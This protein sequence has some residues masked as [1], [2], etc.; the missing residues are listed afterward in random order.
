MKVAYV[1]ST[2][3]GGGAERLLVNLINALPSMMEVHVIVL[4]TTGQMAEHLRH[5]RATI[6]ALGLKSHA[7]VAGWIRFGRL[8]ARIR[9]DVV[10]SHMTLSN[11]A[12]RAA[13]LLAPT[14]VL[15]NHEH[16]L[17]VWKGRLLCLLDGATQFLAD[18]VIT[19]SE[20]SRKIRISRERIRPA[21]IVTMHNGT[22]WVRWSNVTPAR[23][24]NGLCLGVAASLTRV[25][26]I[27]LAIRMLAALHARR[28]D[29]RLLV[30]GDG[31]ELAH[32][33]AASRDL[34]VDTCV[35]F[36]G[37]VQDMA[38]FYARVD[39]VLLTSVR[40]DCPMALLEALAA[41]K[42]TVGPSTGGVREILQ[43][44]VE[45]AVIEDAGDFSHVIRRLQD[46]PAGFDSP[47]NREYAKRFDMAE[48]AQKIVSLYKELVERR[49]P[50]ALGT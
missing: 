31:P 2:L 42:F 15:V 27:E 9:P 33:K 49:R 22:D 18:R 41:G 5:P 38:E 30:A 19:A 10:H 46:L 8:L 36:L 21:R 23:Q 25:K 16:G 13:R 34:G 24:G 3:R 11:L 44:P 20:A 17:G 43:A 50:A 47:I 48:Y 29:A 35:E 28:P 12:A 6:H 1:I 39:V 26:R 37:F 7:D 14:T 40:E 32:L 45:G 4:K